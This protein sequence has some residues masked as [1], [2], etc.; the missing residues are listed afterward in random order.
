MDAQGVIGSFVEGARVRA[1]AL[2]T[3][4]DVIG[5]ASLSRAVRNVLVEHPP[6]VSAEGQEALQALRGTYG[7]QEEAARMISAALD[8]VR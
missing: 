5:Q 7:A 1:D 2:G 6:P 8:A 4:A 3:L